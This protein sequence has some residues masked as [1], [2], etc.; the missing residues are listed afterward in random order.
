MAT[1]EGSAVQEVLSKFDAAN[2]QLKTGAE[3]HDLPADLQ[4]DI[5][6]IS[7][8]KLFKKEL[9][10][11]LQTNDLPGINAARVD[12]W[13]HFIHL[14]AKV[15][16]DSP[17]VISGKNAAAGF[18]SVTVSFELAKQPIGDNMP[19]KVTWT[20]LDKSG[21]TGDIYGINSFLLKP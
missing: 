18:E 7:Q 5:D 17:L 14:Y 20:V 13:I 1:L 8:L 9:G 19:F 2:L 15:A 4:N 12:G 16:A 3:L 6:N 21:R 10:E 11:F